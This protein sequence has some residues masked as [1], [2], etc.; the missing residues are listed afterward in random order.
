MKKIHYFSKLF[1]SLLGADSI[2]LCWGGN[3]TAL[4]VTPAGSYH[5]VSAGLDHS[6]ALRHDLNVLCWGGNAYGQI[7]VPTYPDH[8]NV[9]TQYTYLAVSAGGYFSCGVTTAEAY[10]GSNST[11]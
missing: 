5:S 3:D 4:T 2:I 11:I 7:D 6:C 10:V 1:T 8:L 9:S